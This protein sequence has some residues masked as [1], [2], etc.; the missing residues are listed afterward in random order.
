MAARGIVYKQ[1]YRSVNRPKTPVLNKKHL[2]Y[3]ATRPG[4][5]YNKDCGFC[6]WGK[7]PGM[8]TAATINNLEKAK[9]LVVEDSY[10]STLYRVILSLKHD[11]ALDKGFYERDAWQKLVSQK[12]DIIAKEMDIDPEDFNW[13]ASYH[14][15][16]GHPHVHIIYWDGSDKVRQEHIP[17]PRFE[18]MSEHVRAEFN[19]EIYREEIRQLQAAQRSQMDKIR[20]SLG[21]ELHMDLDADELSKAELKDEMIALL[22]D[23]G[24]PEPLNLFQITQSDYNEVMELFM[25]VVRELPKDGSLK[26]QYMPPEVKS[27][28]DKTSD[29]ILEV[30]GYGDKLDQY[31]QTVREVGHIYGNGEES[32]AWQCD[33]AMERIH[34]ELGNE[35]LAFI[36]EHKLPL[37]FKGERRQFEKHI[38]IKV[39]EAILSDT[40]LTGQYQSIYA[41]LPDEKDPDLNIWT[42]DFRSGINQLAED[43]AASDEELA[44]HQGAVKPALTKIL[45]DQR[46][47][48]HRLYMV[49]HE[50]GAA[51]QRT[52]SSHLL[53]KQLRASM[54]K[55]KGN[56]QDNEDF[57]LSVRALAEMID[58]TDELKVVAYL[59]QEKTEAINRFTAAQ[60]KLKELIC[61]DTVVHQEYISLSN[62][63]P[64]EPAPQ[65]EFVDTVFKEKLEALSKMVIVLQDSQKKKK[66]STSEEDEK[67]AREERLQAFILKIMMSEAGWYC[68]PEVLI[69]TQDALLRSSAAAQLYHCIYAQ[70]PETAIESKELWTT[71][72]RNQ[73]NKLVEQ[74]TQGNA[75]LSSGEVK[76]AITRLLYDQRDWKHRQYSLEDNPMQK[77]IQSSLRCHLLYKELRIQI[78]KLKSP[79]KDEEFSKLLHELA[80]QLNAPAKD[81]LEM[82]QQEKEAVFAQMAAYKDEIR[83]LVESDLASNEVYGEL[84]HLFPE[85]VT[86]REEFMNE[87][88]CEKLG[89]L[90]KM[91][92]ERQR[93]QD[94]EPITE[95][96]RESQCRRIEEAV[97]RML[98]EDKG[99]YQ[100]QSSYLVTNLLMSLFR[101]FSRNLN[102]QQAKNRA[103]LRALRGDLSK[104]ARR[105]R[106]KEQSSTSLDWEIPGL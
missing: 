9:K 10:V 79:L 44:G 38:R 73:I 43:I 3:I 1:W 100:A 54:F 59:C 104:Q 8:A 19:R 105:E 53:Y 98:A 17:A 103:K 57:M 4:A 6:L 14:H 50:I 56:L 74:I 95:K 25:A 16:K 15:S 62:E 78:F 67:E 76:A 22:S 61:S 48:N 2:I 92:F 99:W 47:W 30:K 96:A 86:P 91:I 26:Y 87:I 31:L 5:I 36:R 106:A 32:I 42:K 94:S 55:V 84:S 11:D 12:I 66:P 35:M 40:E 80:S 51:I 18:V 52:L 70:V 33:R 60:K 64:T 102:G 85:Q 21:D 83:Q 68:S 63:I 49:E 34:K 82:L 71:D 89:T 75:T 88:F 23:L 93:K 28:L 72:F 39:Q 24:Q 90:A 27:L 7:V 13:L 29:R 101:A 65:E 58:E 69:A 41:Q 97:L 46:D 81:I 20:G 37:L 45:F 77:A